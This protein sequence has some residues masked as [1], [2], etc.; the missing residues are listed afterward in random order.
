M[1]GGLHVLLPTKSRGHQC[2]INPHHHRRK[3]MTRQIVLC[4]L[5][6]RIV[7][8]E[9]QIEEINVTIKMS[10]KKTQA[11]S[12]KLQETYNKLYDYIG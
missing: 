12:E 4:E 11:L 5:E 1:D 2:I 10:L 9:Y 7:S 6:A 8:L 3:K